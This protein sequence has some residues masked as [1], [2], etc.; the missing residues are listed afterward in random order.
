MSVVNFQGCR[1]SEL[2]MCIC[3][4]SP[5]RTLSYDELYLTVPNQ[6]PAIVETGFYCSPNS[7]Q[8]IFLPYRENLTMDND[9]ST[10][11][12]PTNDKVFDA[13]SKKEG[14]STI[15][16]TCDRLALQLTKMLESVF[17]L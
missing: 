1:F 15:V 16:S 4:Q 14:T 9:S 6:N 3:P 17:L 8:K 11:S 10:S 12:V 13:S 2:Q 7:A 5:A